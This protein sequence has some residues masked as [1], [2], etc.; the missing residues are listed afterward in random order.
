MTV[1]RLMLVHRYKF[2]FQNQQQS[3]Q[4]LEIFAI[5]ITRNLLCRIHVYN[6]CMLVRIGYSHF[7]IEE[8]V[9]VENHP[10]ESQYYNQLH[11]PGR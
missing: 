2:G 8:L 10:I 7:L 1:L 6:Q 5:G 11:K 4:S 3:I 9:H